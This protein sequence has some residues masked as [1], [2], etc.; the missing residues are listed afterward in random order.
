MKPHISPRPNEN[1]KAAVHQPSDSSIH[2]A[3]WKLQAAIEHPD[4]RQTVFTGVQTIN[5]RKSKQ[6][7]NFDR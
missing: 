6:V 1:A 7:I 5:E 2:P 3:S 4:V